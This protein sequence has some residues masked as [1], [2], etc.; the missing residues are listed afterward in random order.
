MK[1]LT[2]NIKAILL[3]S[4]VF[5]A[6]G[7]AAAQTQQAPEEDDAPT[8][9]NAAGVE[10]LFVTGTF[11]PDEKRA[12]SE[13]ADLIDAE[14]F[15]QTGDSDIAVALTRVTGLSLVDGKFVFVR[16]LGQRYSNAI[17][18][19][20]ALPSPE[21][22]SRT[23]PL[24][25][26]PTALIGGTLIQKTFSPEYPGQFGGGIISIRTKSIPEEAFL[27]LGVSTAFNTVSTIE[28]GLQFEGSTTDFLGI[29]GG[30]RSLPAELA[31]DPL[32]ES[33]F[34]ADLEAA[35]E[36]LPNIYSLDFEPLAPDVNINFS[37]GN[38]FD[39]GDF[40]LGVLVAIDY[41]S[42]Q[43]NRNGVRNTFGA[44]DVSSGELSTEDQINPEACIAAGLPDEL[45]EGC[46]VR[47]TIWE[48]GL[49]GVLALGLDYGENHS[50]KYVTTVLRQTTQEGII[51]TGNRPSISDGIVADIRLDQIERQVW[52]NQ[53]TGEHFLPIWGDSGFLTGDFQINWRAAYSAGDRDVQLRRE[54]FYEFQPFFGLFSL[55]ANDNGNLTS[56]GDLE[57]ETLDFGLDITQPL[58]IANKLIDMKFGFA[59]LDQSR[60]SG[61][62]RYF[63]DVPVGFGI[64]ELA[65]APESI[66]SPE[67]IAPGGFEISE[68]IDP[69][70]AFTASFTNIQAYVGFDVELIPEKLRAAVGFRY[71]NSE[72]L[73]TTTAAIF[74]PNAGELITDTLEDEFFLPAV[75]LTY[76]FLENLQLRFAYS[77]T[78]SRPDLRELSLSA[79]LDN[80]RDRI[81]IGNPDLVNTELENFDLRL[82]WYFARDEFVTLGFFY[83]DLTNPIERTF[84]L[85][86]NVPFFS[87]I[88]ADNGKLIGVEGEVKKN[89][90]INEWLDW[91]IVKDKEFYVQ[92]NAAYIDS[93]VTI[94]F[95]PPGTVSP[96]NP[97]RPLQGQ[98]NVIVNFR[99]GYDDF[100]NGSR[101]AFLLNFTNDR[102]AEVGLGI[103]PEPG[104]LPT[105]S[106]DVIENPPLMVD[107]V[108]GKS[109]ELADTAFEFTFK[110]SNLLNDDIFLTQGDEI[111]ENF[112]IG[113]TFSIGLKASF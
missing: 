30:L 15:L 103:S 23:I 11:I 56:F 81:V 1:P 84:G 25:I 98:S 36:A 78:L 55:S 16:G 89:L 40:S 63:F 20:A 69:S 92:L 105:G 27:N 109:F 57:D 6:P 49:N 31:A 47:S 72:Q 107:F 77:Q 59:Y 102:I 97:V 44:F 60:D 111:F 19:G 112:T 10:E 33:T 13:I 37:A 106:P 96:T 12:T 21:P 76:S 108:Y 104:E 64:L 95:G 71:E 65:Q 18:D 70:D 34:G 52:F 48:V 5:L 113:R 4:T 90:P 24:D 75:T 39:L 8:P 58:T 93:E 73:T 38:R 66:F 46:G 29:D 35:G 68:F 67:N 43:R 99:I 7:L 100:E 101:A 42:E 17:L 54:Y 32:L 61:F 86:G 22:L 83:K 51:E 85:Q 82:E 110:A 62:L 74:L 41:G 26:F 14:D 45:V 94:D 28:D 88:N 50:V 80:E 79:F 2:P 87:F 9:S 53:L 91:S 3:A